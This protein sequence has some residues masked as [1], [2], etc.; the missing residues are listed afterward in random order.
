MSI[1][2]NPYITTN[3]AG[4]FG[5]SSTGGVQGTA[6]D[7]PNARFNLATG[8]W[9]TTNTLP[10]YGGIGISELL[11]TRLVT[12]PNAELGPLATFATSLTAGATGQLTG[13]SVFDQNHSAVNSPQ[14]SV[15]L[16]GAGGTFNHYRL[17]S[18][19]R[20]W[21]AM[22]QALVSLEGG[23]IGAQVSWDFSANQRIGLGIAAYAAA[24][25]T[26]GTYTTSTGIIAL[27][28]SAAPFGASVGATADGVYVT[29]AGLAGTG[30]GAQL[31]GI[32]PITGTATA[33][34]VISFQGPIGLGAITI[35]GA[36][37][38][39]VAG[40]GFL[41]INILD[42]APGDGQGVSFSSATGFYTWNRSAYLALVSI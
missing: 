10:L 24:T 18:G 39:I 30:N 21:L 23:P 37:G 28:F 34:T 33:G 7:S 1:V 20:L 32:W 17:G 13:W 40:G 6:Y 26:S 2:F 11:S 14:S 8:V 22:D 41:P 3:A 4:S 42:I 31:N 15:P 29:L 12:A 36:T 9:S 35:T 38:G 27:T 16:V 5:T 19:A 25:I